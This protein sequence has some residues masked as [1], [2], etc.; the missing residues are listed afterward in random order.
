MTLLD[1]VALDLRNIGVV[2]DGDRQIRDDLERSARMGS[3]MN[4]HLVM[5]RMQVARFANEFTE[6]G[7]KILGQTE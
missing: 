6:N 2:L 1:A 3:K 5:L 7:A 4:E